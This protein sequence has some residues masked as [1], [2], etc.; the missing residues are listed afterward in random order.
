M[1]LL[2]LNVP[3]GLSC[4]K[5]YSYGAGAGRVWSSLLKPRPPR[6]VADALWLCVVCHHPLPARYQRLLQLW[7][8]CSNKLHACCVLEQRGQYI[9]TL[10]GDADHNAVCI[11]ERLEVHWSVVRFVRSVVSS[12]T[13][14]AGPLGI[15]PCTHAWSQ[16]ALWLFSPQHHN[17]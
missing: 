12:S 10:Y 1:F 5:C 16:M 17:M 11:G 2:L 15:F 3:S 8:I 4:R 13:R 7:F 14:L 9:F 6:H